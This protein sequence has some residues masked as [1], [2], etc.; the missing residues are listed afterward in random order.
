MTYNQFFNSYQL[1]KK[2]SSDSLNRVHRYMKVNGFLD[3]HQITSTQA[4]AALILLG[5]TATKSDLDT[6]GRELLILPTPGTEPEGILETISYSLSDKMNAATV[7]SLVFN[8]MQGLIIFTLIDD[9]RHVVDMN[10]PIQPEWKQPGGITFLQHELVMISDSLNEQEQA[11]ELIG[12]EGF[13]NIINEH[14]KE[15]Q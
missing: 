1:R 11:G 7:Q 6:F 15:N 3:T 13:Q 9:S 2:F 12:E 4:A 10:V 14:D 5:C 8:R